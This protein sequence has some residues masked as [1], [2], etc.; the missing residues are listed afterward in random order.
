MTLGPGRHTLRFAAVDAEGRAGSLDH[1]FSADLVKGEGAAMGDVLLLEPLT[2]EQERL[3]VATDGR[4][5]ADAI[6]A[7]LEI[8]PADPDTFGVTVRFEVS[9]GPDREPR[10]SE[11]GLMTR[12]PATGHWS[13]TARLDLAGIPPGD[14]AVV[15]TVSAG[16]R[17]LG[18]TERAIHIGAPAR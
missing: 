12:S 9:E 17:V 5:R 13:A 2:G 1:V 18:R 4:L 8:V 6:D 10:V 3:E 15:A 16:G 14:Y 7:Y 11:E